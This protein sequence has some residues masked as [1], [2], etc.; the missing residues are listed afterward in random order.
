M[1]QQSC[2]ISNTNLTDSSFLLRFERNNFEFKPGQYIVMHI[3]GNSQCREYSIYSGADKPYIEILVKEVENGLFST[4]LKKLKSGN[5]IE[6]EGPFGFFVLPEDSMFS[7]KFL[8]IA[9]GTGI[10]PF[11][12]F[13]SSYKL[14]NITVLHG[15]SYLN[16]AIG[17][18]FFKDL[19][20][21][22]CT[23]KSNTGQFQGRVT[24]WLR[25]NSISQK[26]ICYLCGNANMINEAS[27]ILE[28]YNIP[29][30]NIRSEVFF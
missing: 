9:T 17:S 25:H 24:S 5:I 11:N 18:N 10:S 12:S 29:P 22:T 2:I 8:F 20:Y 28:A 30:E 14:S 23:S 6:F 16:E 7:K 26:T 1:R 4:S 13:L 3:P 21:I 19:D 27:D 15:I